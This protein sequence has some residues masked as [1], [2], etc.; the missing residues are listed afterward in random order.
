MNFK[1]VNAE[2]SQTIVEN[3]Y[4]SVTQQLI[5][6]KC[7]EV[8]ISHQ[9][10]QASLSLFGGHVLSWKPIGHDEV[11]WLSKSAVFDAKTAIRGGIPLC[12]PWFGPYGE[13]GN[14]GFARTSVWEL[15]KVDVAQH[16]VTVEL[17][18]S[19]ANFSQFWPN[20]F[21]VKQI[22]TFSNTFS[23]QLIIENVSDEDF[24]FTDALHTYFSVSSPEN[25]AIPELSN[26]SYHDKIKQLSNC[27]P[28]DVFDCIGP[29]DKIYHSDS[30]MTM[31][32]K[33][34]KRA[35]EINKS[36]S[37]QWVL[38]NP[39]KEIAAGMADIHQNGEDEFVCLEA[40]NTNWITVKAG[41]TAEVSQEIQV[42]KL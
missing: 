29:I 9:T 2:N 28:K 3:E 33:G 7:T 40:A 19:G 37:S 20:K 6:A 13:A 18:L 23:Q 8:S 39:G 32:D 1:V 25:V 16:S 24:Q 31:F 27:Q 10:C 22:I 14:H 12:W 5:N 11:F 35:I 15:S 42:Y 4:G 26:S 38:W 36:N 21:V 41:E 17:T 34:W 30:S